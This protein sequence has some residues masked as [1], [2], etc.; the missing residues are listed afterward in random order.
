MRNITIKKNGYLV[1][2]RG[3]SSNNKPECVSVFVASKDY[4]SIPKA[5]SVAEEVRDFFELVRDNKRAGLPALQG[6]GFT[7]TELLKAEAESKA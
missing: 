2:V 6:T 4:E 5:L 1:R 7:A 3:T